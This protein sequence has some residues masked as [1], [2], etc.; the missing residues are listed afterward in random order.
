LRWWW[1]KRASRRRTEPRPSR[2]IGSR[3]PRSVDA[4]DALE[5]GAPLLWEHILGNR[6]L[7]AH[8]GDEA[9]TAAAFAARPIAC[10]W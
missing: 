9:A 5:D 6:T 1:P 10:G 4:L 2:S 3:C 7:E 8:L